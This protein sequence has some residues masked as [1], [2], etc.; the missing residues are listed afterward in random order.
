M[1]SSV[2]GA[3]LALGLLIQTVG[4]A[5]RSRRAAPRP[6]S[7]ESGLCS[8][9]PHANPIL[10]GGR[11]GRGGEEGPGASWPAELSP[12]PALL[13]STQARPRVEAVSCR[14]V[15]LSI[16][17]RP[18]GPER[19][20]HPHCREEELGEGGGRAGPVNKLLPSPHPALTPQALPRRKIQLVSSNCFA[21]E[22][23]KG[24]G[25]KGD[26]PGGW[27]M[28][29]VGAGGGD[30]GGKRPACVCVFL[31][32]PWVP[33]CPR[34]SPAETWPHSA[35]HALV[36]L[37]PQPYLQALIP[38]PRKEAWLGSGGHAHRR[39]RPPCKLHQ[40]NLQLTGGPPTLLVH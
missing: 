26:P 38:K 35:L 27:C 7:G 8:H 17:P 29:C 5:P 36:C 9:A 31:L 21:E 14:P 2:R 22:P 16:V 28:C 25:E 19:P 18:L 3:C 24:A 30:V 20:P 37:P 4:R 1:A 13:S 33:V 40:A 11:R 34:L 12:R 23:E 32:S 6:L 39:V 10:C 15:R